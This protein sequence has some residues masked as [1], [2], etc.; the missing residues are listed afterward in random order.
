MFNAFRKSL[1]HFNRKL[2]KCHYLLQVFNCA[3][4][5]DKIIAINVNLRRQAGLTHPQ[6]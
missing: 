6:S 3:V 4:S 1:L 5:T 2:I